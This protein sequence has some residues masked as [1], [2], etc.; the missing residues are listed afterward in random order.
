MLK[1]CPKGQEAHIV[2]QRG[3]EWL[4]K[5]WILIPY[6]IF[7]MYLSPRTW[8]IISCERLVM[9]YMYMYMPTEMCSLGN[10]NCVYMASHF[11][12]IP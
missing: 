2:V 9:I 12:N 7:S 11:T 4:K 10:T 5:A 8:Y 6:R 3:G 1:D